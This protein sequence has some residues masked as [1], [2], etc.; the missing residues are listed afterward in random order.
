MLGPLLLAHHMLFI[1]ISTGVCLL[2]FQPLAHYLTFRKGNLCLEK[3]Q[4][5]YQHTL[6]VES[7]LSTIQLMRELT[8]LHRQLTSMATSVHISINRLIQCFLH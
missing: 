7:F 8:R 6:L 1:F 3:S 4:L 2:H 5:L